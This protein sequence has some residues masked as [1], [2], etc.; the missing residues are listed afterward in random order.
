MKHR[1]KN[2]DCEKVA[3]CES[4]MKMYVE[5][6]LLSTDEHIEK[7]YNRCTE[8][9]YCGSDYYGILLNYCISQ[10]VSIIDNM[11]GEDRADMEKVFK[12]FSLALLVR[13]GMMPE[14]TN[15]GATIN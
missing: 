6:M 4:E 1:H 11:C 14:K 12:T 15:E 8:S 13:L 7:L 10:T 2:V 5:G 9:N 3:M